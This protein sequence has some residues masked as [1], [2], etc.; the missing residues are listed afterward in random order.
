MG[1]THVQFT[2]ASRFP[3]GINGY[4][5]SRSTFSHEDSFGHHA[6]YRQST[7]HSTDNYLHDKNRDFLVEERG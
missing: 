4:C 2:H 7:V 3:N 1:E 6:G 5:D